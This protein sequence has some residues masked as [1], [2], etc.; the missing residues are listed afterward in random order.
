MLDNEPNDSR[1]FVMSSFELAR[2]LCCKTAVQQRPH[3][4]TTFKG[5]ITLQKPSK[6][7]QVSCLL[8]VGQLVVTCHPQ[9]LAVL[10]SLNT[11][12]RRQLQSPVVLANGCLLSLVSSRY[13]YVFHQSGEIGFYSSLFFLQ[14]DFLRRGK[15]RIFQDDGKV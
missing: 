2:S 13:R 10:L 14:G 7:L 4:L 6:G 11:S 8:E 12:Q 1:Q 9:L 5:Y 3:S 15:Y